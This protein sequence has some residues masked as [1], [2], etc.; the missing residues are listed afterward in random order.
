MNTDTGYESSITGFIDYTATMETG[1]AGVWQLVGY[2]ILLGTIVSLLPQIYNLIK[3]KSSYGMNP[4]TL[5][6]SNFSQYILVFNIIC[7]RSSDFIAACQVSFF[8]ILPRLMTFLNAFALW[9]VYLP[10]IVLNTLYFDREVRPYRQQEAFKGEWI[11]NRLFLSLNVGGSMIILII[12]FTLLLTTGI[13]SEE[14]TM[15][16]KTFGTIALLAVVVQYLPQFITTCK[17]RDNGSFSLILL[18][19][20]APG[21][22]ASALFM[23]IGQGDHWTTWMSTLAASVQ[24]FTLLFL[25]IFFKIQKRRQTRKQ[26]ASPLI[27]DSST[28]ANMIDPH[29]YDQPM[30]D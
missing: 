19:L 10:I 13:G 7:L 27:D 1:S 8:Q 11:F 15:M 4:M 18:A 6:V 5:F 14:I 26:L 9:I 30:L 2:V 24:Q 29:M 28:T 22:T 16:G 23:A 25:C 17:L 21:G 3:R 12:Y 20:Q